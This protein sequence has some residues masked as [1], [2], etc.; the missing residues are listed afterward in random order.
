MPQVCPEN[1][2]SPDGNPRYPRV[3]VANKTSGGKTVTD[4][5]TTFITPEA[6]LAHWQGHQR[7]T[8]RVIDAFPEDKLFAFT[9]APPMRSFG[10]LALE[11][12]NMVEPTLQG[13]KTG[14]WPELDWEAIRKQPQPSKKELLGRWDKTAQ[15]LRERWPDIAER[16]FHEVDTAF[17]MWTQPGADLVLYLIDNEIHHRAQGYVYLRLLGIEPPAFYER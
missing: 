10:V 2:S 17:G 13:L 8:R 6:L 14:T 9:P 3:E 4:T 7:L 1:P 16:R 11:V 12:I 5:M 15:A